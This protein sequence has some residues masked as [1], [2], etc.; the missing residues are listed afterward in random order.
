MRVAVVE[1]VT[2][3][4]VQVTDMQAVAAAMVVQLNTDTVHTMLKLTQ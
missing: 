3:V 4:N 2:A 1:V